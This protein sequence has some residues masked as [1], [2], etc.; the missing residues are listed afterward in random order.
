MFRQKS[1]NKWDDVNT[2]VNLPKKYKLRRLSGK[3]VYLTAD[4]QEWQTEQSEVDMGKVLMNFSEHTSLKKS[5]LSA[6]EHAFVKPLVDSA[7]LIRRLKKQKFSD[8]LIFEGLLD[9]KVLQNLYSILT[10]ILTLLKQKALAN[11][12][13]DFTAYSEAQT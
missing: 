13:K 6:V 12:A 9:R 3:N 5:N 11:K 8:N 7:Y 1:G 10:S 4:M 2:F